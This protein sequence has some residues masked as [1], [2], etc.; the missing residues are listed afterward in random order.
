MIVD[1]EDLGKIYGK[2]VYAK[3]KSAILC[4]FKVKN[5]ENYFIVSTTHLLANVPMSNVKMA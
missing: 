5:T 4:L 1:F 2:K 3:S